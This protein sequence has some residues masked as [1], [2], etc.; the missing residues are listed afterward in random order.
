MYWLAVIIGG[1][2][3]G[4]VRRGTQ[5]FRVHWL[6]FIIGGHGLGS[7]RGG[8]SVL[9]SVLAG[10]HYHRAWVGECERGD[11]VLQSTLDWS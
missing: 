4:S 2:G 6:V 7:V 9:S 11:S 5:S 1:H 10:V 8:D 3:L